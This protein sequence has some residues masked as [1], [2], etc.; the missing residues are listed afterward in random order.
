MVDKSAFQG[1]SPRE[2][3]WL[4]HHFRLNLPPVFFAEVLADLTKRRPTTSS[5][6]NDVITLARKI[7]THAV[8]PNESAMDLLRAELGGFRFPLRG[9]IVD[10]QA[11]LIK[12]PDGTKNIFID[13]TPTQNLIERWANGD[14]ET[15][16]RDFAKVWRE[17][18][19]KFKLEELFRSLKAARRA[20]VNK[21]ADVIK[22]VDLILHGRDYEMLKRALDLI[23]AP[24]EQISAVIR[25]WRNAGRPSIHHYIP[26]TCFV[27]R[28]ELF[29]LLGLA[30]QVV[31]TRDTNRI[32]I[33]Y[34][35]YLPFTQVFCSSDK[36]HIEMA[37]H[38][39]LPHNHFVHGS[40]L[41]KA[42]R[43]IADHWEA[44]TEEAKAQGSATYADVP[45]PQFDNV[46]TQA[47]DH[48]VPGWRTDS[49]KPRPKMSVEQNEQMMKQIRARMQA[50]ERQRGQRKPE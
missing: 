16:E 39:L 47:Y 45:P 35:K 30:H 24:E 29:F 5:P 7:E 48:C 33:E 37:P 34:L 1:L 11:E 9:Q 41:K 3:K 8:H 50:I 36:L 42:M 46:V 14:F 12:L 21:V 19:N 38:F 13:S 10:Q 18:L 26:Y 4:A 17:G 22:L 2:A 43:E 32:D 20:H 49:N 6:E 15:A 31:T 44:V 28:I 23:E 40:D 25:A 27:L